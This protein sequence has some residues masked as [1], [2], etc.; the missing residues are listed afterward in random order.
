MRKVKPVEVI[1]VVMR[2]KHPIVRGE[3]SEYLVFIRFLVFLTQTNPDHFF[4]MTLFV[5]PP[6]QTSQQFTVVHMPFV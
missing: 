3:Y 5:D 4:V 6:T 2:N 1:P